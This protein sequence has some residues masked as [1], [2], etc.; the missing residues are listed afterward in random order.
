MP[1]S[2]GRPVTTC[3]REPATVSTTSG[4]RFSLA[5]EGVTTT[6]ETSTPVAVIRSLTP[7]SSILF[8]LSMADLYTPFMASSKR[9][10]TLGARNFNNNIRP[11]H[12][13]AGTAISLS[14]FFDG[15]QLLFK[16]PLPLLQFP[17]SFL[18]LRVG[19]LLLQAILCRPHSFRSLIYLLLDLIPL[20]GFPEFGEVLPV[21][22]PGIQTPRGPDDDRKGRDDPSYFC[23]VHPSPPLTSLCA[24]RTCPTE[25]TS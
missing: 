5:G 20:E 2:K 21:S 14:S 11:D 15:V 17:L 19:R 3:N 8:G 22:P 4:G 9:V 1:S 10:L 25:A 18:K 23:E 13:N 16:T 24:L 12:T 6:P 7:M